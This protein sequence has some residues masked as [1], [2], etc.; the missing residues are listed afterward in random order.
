MIVAAAIE[1]NGKVYSL[2]KP[3]R[4][5]HIVEKI[6]RE[7]GKPVTGVYGFVDEL[8]NFYNRVDAAQHAIGCKQLKKI[9]RPPNLYSE[10]LW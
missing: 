9:P 10:D 5:S 4:H 7:T 1:Q 8:G 2:P 3:A 6:I